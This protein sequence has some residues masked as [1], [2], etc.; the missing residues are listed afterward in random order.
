MHAWVTRVEF[1]SGLVLLAY[2][3]AAFDPRAA[4]AAVGGVLMFDAYTSKGADP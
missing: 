4:V 1:I 3:I 2:G